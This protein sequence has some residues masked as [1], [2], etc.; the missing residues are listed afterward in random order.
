MPF[1]R[2]HLH[3]STLSPSSFPLPLPLPLPFPFPFPSLPPPPL[4]PSAPEYLNPWKGL[5]GIDPNL[6]LMDPGSIRISR[7]R[8]I[9]E[10][11]RKRPRLIEKS[12]NKDE[13]RR[14]IHLIRLSFIP[15]LRLYLWLYFCFQSINQPVEAPVN[16]WLNPTTKQQKMA[17]G[18]EMFPSVSAGGA[19]CRPCLQ[20]LLQCCQTSLWGCMVGN[21]SGNPSRIPQESL[22]NRWGL[23]KIV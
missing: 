8:S 17:P 14:L 15:V 6:W 3:K 22:K 7:R 2:I 21:G 1:W 12:V 5:R 9:Y 23:S 4:S 19:G 16:F 20:A 13:S 10:S 11:V 18:R